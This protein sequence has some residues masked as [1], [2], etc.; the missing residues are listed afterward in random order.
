MQKLTLDI[1]AGEVS[2]ELVR[3]G[4]AAKTRVRVQVEVFDE[5]VPLAST[6][7]AGRAFDFLAD[8]P[9]LYSD[10]DLIERA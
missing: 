1:V 5:A 6:A 2:R 9:D 4:I 10:A 3:R 7:Q 8:E